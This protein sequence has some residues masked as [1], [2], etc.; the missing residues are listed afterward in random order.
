MNNK[1]KPKTENYSKQKNKSPLF[2][3][4]LAAF[5]NDL[6]A[7]LIFPIWPIFLTSIMGANM[8]VLGLIDGLGDSIVSISQAGSGY[9][10]DRIKKRKPFIWLG[11]L[12]GGISR[13]GYALSTTWPQLIPFRILDRAGKIRDAP[14]DA[15]VADLSNLKNRTRNFGYLKAMDKFGAVVGI[16]LCIILLNYFSYSQ[17]FIIASIPSII[18]AIMVIA[19]IREHKNKKLKI[20]KGIQFKD[21][22]KDFKTYLGLSSLL[23]LAS[24]SYSFLL[25][26][27]KQQG[28]PDFTLPILYLAF[29]LTAAAFSLP[30]GQLADKIGRKQVM[31]ISLVLWITTCTV[32]IF[33]HQYWAIG[34]CFILYGLHKASLEPTQKAIVSDLAPRKFRASALGG[35]EMIL[36][37]CALPSSVIAGILWETTNPETVFLMAGTLTTCSILL[38]IL[39]KHEK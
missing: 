30:F 19:L 28:F 33:L 27:A 10:S 29:T 24:F 6:G 11:Y 15:I 36:G 22:S 12:I 32:F 37:L 5:L 4:G 7:Y 17:V 20:F 23:A 3:F 39:V 34:L 21:I 26:F 8:A 25:L 14:R 13:I 16:I 31:Y 35:F 1:T 2:I 9:A 38:L 18:G